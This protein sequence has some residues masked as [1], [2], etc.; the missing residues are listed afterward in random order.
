MKVFRSEILICSFVYVL[1]GNE[2]FAE[3]H[4]CRKILPRFDALD[5]S[6]EFLRA[7]NR[8][9]GCKDELKNIVSRGH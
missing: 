4:D 2:S 1:C 7:I 9:E 8:I 3:R 6:G 5:I